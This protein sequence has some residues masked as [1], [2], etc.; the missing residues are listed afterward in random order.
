M[1]AAVGV[2]RLQ[3]VHP[4]PYLSRHSSPWCLV[5][6]LWAVCPSGATSLS[7]IHRLR[8]KPVTVRGSKPSMPPQCW[9]G[10]RLLPPSVCVQSVSC[11][12]SDHTSIT[13]QRHQRG[14]AVQG[15]A[16]GAGNPC[17]VPFSE[18]FVCYGVMGTIR[19]PLPSQALLKHVRSFVRF[20]VH[21]LA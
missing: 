21:S 3:S 2:G 18:L 16:T 6:F 5:W 9:V 14:R 7:G 19:S 17:S 15:S 13:L 4:P 11:C 8:V 1:P 20:S 10:D 12:S